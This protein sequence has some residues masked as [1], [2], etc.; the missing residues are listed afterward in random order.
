VAASSR[1]VSL[2][3]A[4]GFAQIRVSAPAQLHLDLGASIDVAYQVID[5]AFAGLPKGARVLL[6]AGRF[7]WFVDTAN[8][9]PV[10][11]VFIIGA[12]RLCVEVS[13]STTD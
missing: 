13:V 5:G 3:D 10:T 8:G 7:E 11:L 9:L 6:Q 1:Q 2:S 4:S 12:R